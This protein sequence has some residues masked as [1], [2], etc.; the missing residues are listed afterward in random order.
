MMKEWGY[1]V[2]IVTLDD[3]VVADNA[4]VEGSIDA[5]LV[6]ICHIWKHITNLMERICMHVSLILCPVWIQLYH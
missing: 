4:L 5:V 6:S 3:P 1:N 2:E